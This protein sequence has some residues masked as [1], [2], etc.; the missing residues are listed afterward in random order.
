MK[1][2]ELSH[3]L[4]SAGG[5]D[6]AKVDASKRAKV[7]KALKAL[8]TVCKD[9]DEN[10]AEASKSMMPGGFETLSEKVRMR[11]PMTAAEAEKFVKLSKEFDKTVGDATKE[12]GDIEALPVFEKLNEEEFFACLGGYESMPDGL[13][14][15]LERVL[16]KQDEKEIQKE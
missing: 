6:L 12:L 8:R 3:L 7:Y 4:R 16:C 5:C 10:V 14:E 1:V 11:Q 13:A 15:K 2:R 9:Y